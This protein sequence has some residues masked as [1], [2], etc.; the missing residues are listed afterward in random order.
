M[1][2]RRNALRT[3]GA[4]G[5]I[6]GGAALGFG[7]GINPLAAARSVKI[8]QAVTALAFIQNYVAQSQG[9]FKDEGLDAE[10]VDTRG[11]GPDVQMVLA[12][13]A[14]FTTND[15][16]QVLPALQKGQRLTCVLGLLNRSIINVTMRK[17]TAD[18][19]G[20]KE[21]SSFADKVA[22]LGGLKIG[23]TRPGAL[24]W[25]VARANLTNAGMDPDSG[26]SIIGVG[27]ASALAAAL[28]NGDIDVMYISVPIGDRVVARGKAITLID[29]SR[30]EDPN[31]PRFLM[32][33]LWVVPEFLDQE[34]DTVAKAV[35]ALHRASRFIVE[36]PAERTAEAVSHVFGA[37]D[38]PVL[39]EGCSKVKAAVSADGK[40]SAEE[41]RFTMDVL[42]TNGFLEEEFTL[43]DVFDGR[44]LT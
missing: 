28:E 36:N 14:E 19:L 5:A 29:N 32:E 39:V 31:I 40:V 38:R 34:P 18:R 1:K 44:F 25:Q 17:Q 7:V 2:S 43:A 26:A 15:G 35:R 13:R 41:L 9:F 33:G 3:I 8:T 23:V 11:G 22:A 37:I 20:L 30:G 4:G 10:L 27:G 6:L 16:A 42:R 24:T 12:G 21:S